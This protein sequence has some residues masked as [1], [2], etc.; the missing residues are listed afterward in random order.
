MFVVHIAVIS[1]CRGM[2]LL[3]LMIIRSCCKNANELCL[4][5]R[6]SVWRYFLET[7]YLCVWSK[8]GVERRI[9]RWY[10]EQATLVKSKCNFSVV[11]F[12]ES[13]KCLS[14]LQNPPSA[15]TVLH[16]HCICPVINPRVS[17]NCMQK[18]S[19]GSTAMKMKP[20]ILKSNK[21]LRTNTLAP[22]KSCYHKINKTH[23][24]IYIISKNAK[25]VSI[26]WVLAVTKPTAI[27]RNLWIAQNVE[28]ISWRM[29]QKHKIYA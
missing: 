22:T 2:D 5:Q 18:C 7:Q 27:T 3:S 26:G 24:W 6:V 13:K 8:M 12:I 16:R 4:Q 25:T 15:L 11:N 23:I 17:A 14:D 29:A 28:R 10:T 21:S 19:T 9:G 1:K 20:T